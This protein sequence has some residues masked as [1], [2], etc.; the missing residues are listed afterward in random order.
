MNSSVCQYVFMFVFMLYLFM[1]IQMFLMQCIVREV[2]IVAINVIRN[3]SYTNNYLVRKTKQTYNNLPPSL[4]FKL[5]KRKIQ[6]FV[7]FSI[8][9]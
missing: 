7:I 9:F 5:F 1:C 8:L 4:C 3:I 6:I 2:L